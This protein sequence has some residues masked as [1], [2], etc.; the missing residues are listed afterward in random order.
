MWSLTYIGK[1]YL[2][3]IIVMS[4]IIMLIMRHLIMM[5]MMRYPDGHTGYGHIRITILELSRL[6]E[7]RL[8]DVKKV[9]MCVH[10][11]YTFALPYNQFNLY[12]LICPQ[13]YNRHFRHINYSWY[14]T[15]K[16][17]IILHKKCMIYE[18]LVCGNAV[19]QSK[20]LVW[21]CVKIV[22]HFVVLTV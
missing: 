12:I 10:S 18:C 9:T 8:H 1:Q 4:I 20:F 2:I 15:E 7:S 17:S 19:C 11:I 3:I 21:H 22:W 6:Y 16:W 5:M 13:V 14:S